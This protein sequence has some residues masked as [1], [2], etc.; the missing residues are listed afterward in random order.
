MGGT[1]Y[2]AIDQMEKK[3]V[4]PEYIIGWA[5]GFL[6]NPRREEQRINEA[7]EAGYAHGLERNTSDFQTWLKK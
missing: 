5:C 7:Y 1:Y 2:D 6:H 3:G 4:D